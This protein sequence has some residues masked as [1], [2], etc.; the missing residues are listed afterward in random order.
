MWHVV[1]L[2]PTPSSDDSHGVIPRR[3]G[4]KLPIKDGGFLG[5]VVI[6][7]ESLN[8][9]IPVPGY[10][11]IN[12]AGKD[13]VAIIAQ[14]GGRLKAI[15][16]VRRGHDFGHVQSLGAVDDERLRLAKIGLGQS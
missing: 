14:F 4:F 3:C 1:D 8:A 16:G 2:E 6:L 15:V 9:R 13:G 7:Y 10:A 5:R 12:G 11:V